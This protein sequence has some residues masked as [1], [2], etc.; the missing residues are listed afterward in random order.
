MLR[1][2]RLTW[3]NY[4]SYALFGY[5]LYTFSASAPLLRDDQGTSSA[6]AAAHEVSYA[7]GAVVVGAFG[8]RV[9]RRLGRKRVFWTGL[10]GFGF[11][12]V[13]LYCAAPAPWLSLSA[14]L[15]SGRG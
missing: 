6:V 12:G 11:L 1:R 2:D 4:A 9:V 3:L 8:D 10:F 13:A 14:A 5:F 7:V 15:I